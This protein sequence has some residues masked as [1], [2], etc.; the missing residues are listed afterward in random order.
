MSG[1]ASGTNSSGQAMAASS[2]A[3]GT[4][5]R[6]RAMPKT[7]STA[8]QSSSNARTY[9]RMSRCASFNTLSTSLWTW[10]ACEPCPKQ[11]SSR[12]SQIARPSI[13]MKN[14]RI[15]ISRMVPVSSAMRFNPCGRRGSAST[16]LIGPCST[17]NAPMGI[18][19]GFQCSSCLRNSA[20]SI[21]RSRFRPSLIG[22]CS[23][24]PVPVTASNMASSG[25]AID[26][27]R[28]RE[29]NKRCDSSMIG[30]IT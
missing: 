30:Y 7:T 18:S 22:R 3:S 13:R 1:P 9:W 25:N 20:V 15:G 23:S 5:M 6:C 21:C 8:R 27:S 10:P 19:N 2:T 29:R 11:S 24:T 4:R 12:Q 14:P 17:M 26:A 16:A 28:P